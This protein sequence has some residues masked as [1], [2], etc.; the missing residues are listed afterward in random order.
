MSSIMQTLVLLIAKQP[1]QS[2]MAVSPQTLQTEI[3]LNLMNTHRCTT[4]LATIGICRGRAGNLA[5][6]GIE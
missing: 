2:R 4:C 1:K 5:N 3:G 6:F